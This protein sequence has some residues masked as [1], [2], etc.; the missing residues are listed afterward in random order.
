MTPRKQSATVADTRPLWTD[1][2]V[3]DYF[4][5]RIAVRTLANWRSAG[6]GPPFVRIGKGRG[7]TILYRP[8]AV[9]EWAQQQEHSG[10]V[11]RVA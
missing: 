1:I 5:G 4:A 8:A 7:C 10:S 9:E 11:Q 6:T 3:S 2:D